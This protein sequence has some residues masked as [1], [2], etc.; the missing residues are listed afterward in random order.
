MAKNRHYTINL[1]SSDRPGA[2]PKSRKVRKSSARA[3]QS[4]HRDE[5][6]FWYSAYSAVGGEIL[7]SS[8]I[9]D[10]AHPD[11]R[12]IS[13]PRSFPVC[14]SLGSDRNFPKPTYHYLSRQAGVR[15]CAYRGPTMNASPRRVFQAETAEAD[16]I[17][18]YFYRVFF[19]AEFSALRLYERKISTIILWLRPM[20]T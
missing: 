1:D 9:A 14:P 4:F 20:I 17:N 18:A 10:Q 3:D 19:T 7:Q 13:R 6:R 15:S 16:T 2:V 8:T 12:P 11:L 5:Q